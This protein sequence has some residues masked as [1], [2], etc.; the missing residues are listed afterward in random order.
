MTTDTSHSGSGDGEQRQPAAERN[1]AYV[2]RFR[3]MDKTGRPVN[4]DDTMVTVYYDSPRSRAGRSSVWVS[5][6]LLIAESAYFRAMLEGSFK[7]SITGVIHLHEDSV[8]AANYALR[9]IATGD[10]KS[11]L[12][13]VAQNNDRTFTSI[14]AAQDLYTFTDKYGMTSL[15]EFIVDE[16]LPGV[17]ARVWVGEERT[18]NSVLRCR[19]TAADFKRD[20]YDHF[21]QYFSEFPKD[22]WTLCVA[23]LLHY[24]R[25]EPESGL[26]RRI[27]HAIQRWF[28]M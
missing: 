13:A 26:L 21:T 27:I 28:A 17:W 19:L 23:A 4:I 18:M 7:E 9:S 11:Y 25:T 8:Q 20:H 12:R 15:H 3:R 10:P 2:P 24:Q 14:E 16:M 5:K 1:A 22:L 6:K